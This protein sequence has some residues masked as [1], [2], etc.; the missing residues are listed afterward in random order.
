MLLPFSM[1]SIV[2]SN[3]VMVATLIILSTTFIHQIYTEHKF[4][5]LDIDILYIEDQSK[6]I[7]P[8]VVNPHE[9][10]INAVKKT[11]TYYIREHLTVFIIG[12][13]LIFG[14]SVLYPFVSSDL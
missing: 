11:L 12:V 7:E 6:I 1:Y 5:L 9:F 8:E 10:S 14:Y 4:V 2:S 13:G 3:I